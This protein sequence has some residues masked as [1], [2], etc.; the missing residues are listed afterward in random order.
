M[1]LID[2]AE[3]RAE[4]AWG[5]LDLAQIDDATVRLHWTD[6]P[7]IWHVNDGTEVFVVVDGIVDMHVR[8]GGDERVHELRPGAVFVAEPGDEHR[9]HPR[10]AARIVVVERAGSI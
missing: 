5:S 7:Y 1:R 6:S 10:G 4:R 9:A 8:V 3:F 2:A